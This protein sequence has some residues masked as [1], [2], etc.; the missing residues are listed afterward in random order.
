MLQGFLLDR[1][2]LVFYLGVGWLGCGGVPASLVPEGSR[3]VPAEEVAAWTT[4]TIPTE[5]RLHRFKW[6]FRDERASAGGRGSAR[7]APPDSMR[8]DVAGPFNAD[9]T[10][11]MVVDDQKQWA[12]PPDTAED[13]LPNYPLMW[14]MFGVARAPEA[15]DTVTAFVDT[16]ARIWQYTSG[17]DTVQYAHLGGEK[18]MLVAMVRRAGKLIGRAEAR[19]GP[20]GQLESARLTV[21]SARLDLEFYRFSS[22]DGFPEDIWRPAAP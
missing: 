7:I 5:Y 1:R 4:E 6:T 8:F 21:P 20:E 9:A 16:D 14:A 15:N 22:P 11:A 12:D 18:P 10:A 17:P 13:L 3:P 2:W 19:L